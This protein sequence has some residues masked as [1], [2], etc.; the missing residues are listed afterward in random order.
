MYSFRM[1]EYSIP[2][3]PSV[4]E[5]TVKIG[6]NLD[7]IKTISWEN[8]LSIRSRTTSRLNDFFSLS[9]SVQ[10]KF[11][12]LFVGYWRF[13]ETHPDDNLRGSFGEPDPCYSHALPSPASVAR[14]ERGGGGGADPRLAPPSKGRVRRR[15]PPRP[16]AQSVFVCPRAMP[17]HERRRIVQGAR[18]GRLERWQNVSDAQVL[19]RDV[20]RHV[21]I[22]HR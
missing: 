11:V 12:E 4:R 9:L 2:W 6:F 16:T 10:G 14:V 21:H 13:L 15:T 3:C 19:R 5:Q 20:L 17:W 7:R 8:D 1:W 18:A 22:N